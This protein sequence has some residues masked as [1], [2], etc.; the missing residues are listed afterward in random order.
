MQKYLET[1]VFFKKIHLGETDVFL[2]IAF[3]F[4]T[5][6]LFRWF[7]AC[8]NEYFFSQV[9]AASSLKNGTG[10]NRT[11]KN[12]TDKL[13]LTFLLKYLLSDAPLQQISANPGN[14]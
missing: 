14:N 9:W 1:D 10:K 12:K 4:E 5:W 11:W 13:L 3:H 7:N 8:R 2:K 6:T